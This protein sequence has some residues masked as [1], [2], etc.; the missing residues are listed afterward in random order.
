MFY[1]GVVSAFKTRAESADNVVFLLEKLGHSAGRARRFLDTHPPKQ[2]GEA[3]CPVLSRAVVFVLPE[4]YRQQND[5]IRQAMRTYAC[6]WVTA[7]YHVYRQ[8]AVDVIGNRAD[9]AGIAPDET[10][11]Q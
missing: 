11:A 8:A 4:G 6:D 5:L 10:P 7:K 3:D 1:V 9:W 2:V